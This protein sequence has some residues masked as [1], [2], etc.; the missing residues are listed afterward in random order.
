MSTAT[1][2][3]SLTTSGASERV[4]HSFRIDNTSTDS[5]VASKEAEK[6]AETSVFHDRQTFR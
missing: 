6:I 5:E 3:L 2:Q 4:L 1:T